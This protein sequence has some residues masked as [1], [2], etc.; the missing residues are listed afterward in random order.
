MF[1]M[2]RAYGDNLFSTYGFLDALNPTF[3]ASAAYEF[4]SV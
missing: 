4:A 1:A 3:P 2:R